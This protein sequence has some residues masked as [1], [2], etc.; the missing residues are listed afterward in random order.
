MFARIWSPETLIHCWLGCNMVQPIWK[1][2]L[3]FLINLNIDCHMTQQSP[4]RYLLKWNMFTQKPRHKCLYWLYSKLPK[5]RSNSNVSQLGN[6]QTNARMSIGYYSAVKRNKVITG[7]TTWRNLKCIM[8]R[9]ARFKRLHTNVKSNIKLLCC[10][11]E[12]NITLY[13]NCISIKK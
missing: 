2:F 4:P 6:W 13:V 9:E 8:L 3:Q 12:I 7:T 11:P 5:T 10:I 1:I